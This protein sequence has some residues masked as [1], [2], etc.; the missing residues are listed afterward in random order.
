MGRW[1]LFA[2]CSVIAAAGIGISACSLTDTQTRISE[3]LAGT[4]PATDDAAG[5]APQAEEAWYWCGYSTDP[6]SGYSGL[7]VL[8]PAGECWRAMRVRIRH[9]GLGGHPRL[10]V[11]G[12]RISGCLDDGRDGST[13]EAPNVPRRIVGETPEILSQLH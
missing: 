13:M 8:R 7:Y 6:T 2:W 10:T 9:G 12:H 11:E 1:S 3:S 4:V 5:C